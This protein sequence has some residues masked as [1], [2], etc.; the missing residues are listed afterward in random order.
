[1]ESSLLNQFRS[2]LGQR[3]SA[4]EIAWETL[5]SIHPIKPNLILVKDREP[6]VLYV[7][8]R[9]STRGFWG[10]T[11][12]RVR[13]L[14]AL[15]MRW[16]LVLLAHTASSAHVLMDRQVAARIESGKWKLAPDGDYKINQGPQLPAEA[17]L[18]SFDQIFGVLL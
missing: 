14:C 6:F 12:N 4:A 11:A 10:V 9:S 2:E 17:R 8:E 13:K 7:K 5:T 3:C 16:H 1:M 18:D 15:D